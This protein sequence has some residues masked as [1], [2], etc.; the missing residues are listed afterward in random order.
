MG[1]LVSHAGL[2][3][4]PEQCNISVDLSANV[5]ADRVG[6]IVLDQSTRFRDE[7]YDGA[8]TLAVQAIS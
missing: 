5:P 4:V 2:F 8:G 7:G 1:M 3:G 6:T